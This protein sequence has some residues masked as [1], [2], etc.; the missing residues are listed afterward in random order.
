[1]VIWHIVLRHLTNIFDDLLADHICTEGLLQQHVAAVLFIGQD[2]FYNGDRPVGCAKD[3]FD[4][5]SFQPVLQ[6]AQACAV[7]VSL[8]DLA[9]HLGLLWDNTEFAVCIFFVAVKPVTGDFERSDLCVHLSAAPD[10]AG[11]GLAFGLRH[12]A[13]HRN[14]KFAVWR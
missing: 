8:I 3:G 5:I 2:A 7:L 13:V 9:H 6:I 4:L 10:V 12:R 11:N 14:H 1:M